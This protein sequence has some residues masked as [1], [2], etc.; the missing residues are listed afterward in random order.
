MD[1]LPK[2]TLLALFDLAREDM[3]ADAGSV[4]RVTGRTPTDCAT[5]IVRLDA[6]GL[7]DAT[8]ARLT[9]R[10]LVIAAALRAHVAEGVRRS[11]RTPAS[12]PAAVHAD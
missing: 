3:P 6:L 10:G 2:L 7:C 9:F 11:A 5:A 12:G 1:H 4:A 8:R